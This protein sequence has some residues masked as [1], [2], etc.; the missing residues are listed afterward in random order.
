MINDILVSVI[1]PTYNRADYLGRAIRSVISQTYHNLEIIVVNDNP[2][3]SR[4]AEST[5]EL[6]FGINDPRIVHIQNERNL[7]GVLS[8]NVGIFTAKGEYLCFLDDDDIYKK[9]KVEVQL[10]QMVENDFDMSVTDTEEYNLSTG[11][12]TGAKTQ[13]VRTGMAWEELMRIHVLYHITGTNTFMFR[14]SFIRGFGGFVDVPS[15]QEY[16]LMQKAIEAKPVFGY[17]PGVHGVDYVHPGARITTSVAKLKGMDLILPEKRKYFYLL[18]NKERR[19]VTSRHHVTKA[20][21]LFKLGKIPKFL[22]EASI[23]FLASPGYA[24]GLLLK[25]KSK[26]K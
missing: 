6:V 10:R 2:P 22:V 9:D 24:F 26:L 7:G 25:H 18:N 13:R 15:C 23:G 14:T 19:M 3:S 20:F 5:R 12:R 21:V 1:I 8:R 11:E 17:V 4:A 16:F